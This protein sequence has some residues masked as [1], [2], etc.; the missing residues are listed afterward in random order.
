MIFRG[1]GQV[2]KRAKEPQTIAFRTRNGEWRRVKRHF[3]DG[4]GT[5]YVSRMVLTPLPPKPMGRACR[6]V[7]GMDRKTVAGTVLQCARTHGVSRPF[8]YDS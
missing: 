3:G 2:K 7:I 8:F 5:V 4:D 6:V 1:L